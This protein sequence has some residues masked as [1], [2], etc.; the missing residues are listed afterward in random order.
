MPRFT[1]TTIFFAVALATPILAGDLTLR[2]QT[3]ATDWQTQALP[4]GNGRLGAM[5]FG[6][7]RH[8]RIQLN[9]SSLWTGDEKEMGAYQNLGELT[10]DMSHG[11]E[12]FYRRSL[13]L[14][15]GVHTITYFADGTGYTREYFASY[16]HHAL[17]FHYSALKPGS[18][19]GII[20]FADAHGAPVEIQKNYRIVSA[21]KLPN[22][23]EYETQVIV[24]TSGGK[25]T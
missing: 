17:V 15:T 7:A 14:N 24:L 3:P 9:E 2:Y 5:I 4:I 11:V 22:G 18:C 6:D 21:G 13:D 1:A 19:G 10:F 23:L 20:R 25:V 8:E 16:P 12:T